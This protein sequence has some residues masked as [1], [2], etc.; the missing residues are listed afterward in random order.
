MS[1]LTSATAAVVYGSLV[2][3]YLVG[4]IASWI[5]P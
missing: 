3:A 5:T 2:V 1:P 4:T